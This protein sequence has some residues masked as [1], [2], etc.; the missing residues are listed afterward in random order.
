MIYIY[1]CKKCFYT[2]EKL[3]PNQQ[4][5]Q[6]ECPECGCKNLET[7][8]SKTLSSHIKDYFLTDRS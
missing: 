7:E 3:Y 5:C 8:Q 2:F 6:I 1:I 4:N